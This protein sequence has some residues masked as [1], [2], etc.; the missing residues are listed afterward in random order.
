[1]C[2]CK[3]EKKSYTQI[4]LVSRRFV[5]RNFAWL[6]VRTRSNPPTKNKHEP[7]RTETN[8]PNVAL[9]ARLTLCSGVHLVED[10]AVLTTVLVFYLQQNWDSNRY[11]K[12][13]CFRRLR[14]SFKSKVVPVLN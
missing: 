10:F 9:S 7:T 1:M 11:S 6:P 14:V 4:L 5:L 13:R 3:T 12:I 2:G 8:E